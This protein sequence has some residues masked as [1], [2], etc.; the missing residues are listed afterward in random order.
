MPHSLKN[1]LL[2]SGMIA[3]LAACGQVTE[4]PI[5]EPSAQS[6]A[7]EATVDEGTPSTTAPIAEATPPAPTEEPVVSAT[8]I[9]AA[10]LGMT[11]GELKQTLGPSA[12]FKVEAPFIVDFDAIAVRQNGEPQYYILYLSGQTLTDNDVIEGLYTNNP[13]FRTAEDIGPGS[14]LSKAELAYGKATLSYNL[15]NEG[16]EYARFERQPAANISFG[17]GNAN[18]Q[19]AGI[20][21]N[22]TGEYNETQTYTNEGTVQSVLVVCLTQTCGN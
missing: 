1:G 13:K 20:Y 17:T 2:L 16:R 7:T 19:T 18:Q 3:L 9:G 10:R 14:L 21:A 11:L 22:S 5:A 8:G 15:A 6:N 4:S 12:E